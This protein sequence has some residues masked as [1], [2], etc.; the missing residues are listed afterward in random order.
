MALGCNVSSKFRN[1]GLTV[2]PI[3]GLTS[4]MRVGG[5]VSLGLSNVGHP[6]GIG[7]GDKLGHSALATVGLEPRAGSIVWLPSSLRTRDRPKS[8]TPINE[9][10]IGAHKRAAK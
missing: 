5:C 10:R 7:L 3:V 6:V 8:S 2:V 1:D 4:S 9:I